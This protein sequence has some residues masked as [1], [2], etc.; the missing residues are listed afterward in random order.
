[1]GSSATTCPENENLNM[2][3]EHPTQVCS[4]VSRLSTETGSG[5]QNGLNSNQSVHIACPNLLVAC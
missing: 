1:M 3:V 5:K 4:H 2:F